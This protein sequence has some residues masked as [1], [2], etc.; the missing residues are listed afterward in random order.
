MDLNVTIEINRV[1]QNY[2]PEHLKLFVY[3]RK[4]NL[5]NRMVGK[6][7][8]ICNKTFVSQVFFCFFLYKHAT[9]H[10]FFCLLKRAIKKISTCLKLNEKKHLFK[11]S[12]I[13]TFTQEDPQLLKS[14]HNGSIGKYSWTFIFRQ[15][16]V[17]S[18]QSGRDNLRSA[19]NLR[20]FYDSTNDVNHR[21]YC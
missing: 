3:W 5:K 13:L 18:R 19:D 6:A 9:C 7:G 16:L 14:G 1:C 20:Y 11:P 2:D 12:I 17:F 10:G 21:I 15:E 8:N 4:V